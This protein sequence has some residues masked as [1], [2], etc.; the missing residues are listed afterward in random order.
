MIHKWAELQSVTHAVPNNKLIR[1]VKILIEVL[2]LSATLVAPREVSKRLS[3]LA[4]L[5]AAA[6][7]T[8]AWKPQWETGDDTIMHHSLTGTLMLLLPTGAAASV[9]VRAC[10]YG[11][12]NEPR[13]KTGLCGDTNLETLTILANGR[14]MA[15]TDFPQVL[16]AVVLT[17]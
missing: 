12:R 16:Y 14:Y 1:Y 11:F 3:D 10:D 7:F 4:A 2:V 5:A 13:N 6:A 9:S 8:A 17:A 15:E